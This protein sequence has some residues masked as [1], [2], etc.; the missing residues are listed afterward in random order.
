MEPLPTTIGPL[1]F[2]PKPKNLIANNQLVGTK[3][4]TSNLFLIKLFNNISTFYCYLV[5]MEPEIEADFTFKKRELFNSIERQV[6]EVYGKVSVYT[7]D[8]YFSTK[9][10]ADIKEFKALYRKT[11]A[12]YKVLI[13]LSEKTINVT[14]KNYWRTPAVK[15]IT[16]EMVRK[17]LRANPNLEF[18]RNLFVKKNEMATL[19]GTKDSKYTLNF[20]PG[21]T[22]GIH[23]LDDGTHLCIGLKNKILNTESCLEKLNSMLKSS[24]NR[25]KNQV[26]TEIKEFFQSR[27]VKTKY[28]KNNKNYVINDVNF[29]VNPGNIKFNHKGKEISMLDYYEVIKGCKITDKTQP[30]FEVVSRN[31]DN[32]NEQIIHIVPELCVLSGLDDSMIEDRYFMQELAQYTK[33]QPI[34]RIQ[35]T[36]NFK[37]LINEKDGKKVLVKDGDKTKEVTLASPLEEAKNFGMEISDPKDFKAAFLKLPSLIAANKG[38]QLNKNNGTFQFRQT[39]ETI[40]NLREWICIYNKE[41]YNSAGKLFQLMSQSSKA[42]NIDVKEPTWCETNSF[43]AKDWI[44]GVE[45]TLKGNPNINMVLFLMSKKTKRLYKEIKKHSLIEKGYLSQVVLREN[46]SDKKG[47]SVCSNIVKQ[48]NSKLGGCCYKIQFDKNIAAKNL[49]VVGV[50]SSHISGKRTGVAMCA[51]IDKQ[52]TRYTNYEEIIDEK[53][54]SQLCFAV[55]NFLER[56]VKEYY[57]ENKSLPG[58][59]VIY[60]QGVSAQQKA[61]LDDEVTQIEELLSGSIKKSVISELK[62]PYY[63]VLVNKKTTMKF[64]EKDGK[65][66][67]NS[68]PGM[69]ILDNV[70]DP[71]YHE[72]YIQPQ[73]VNEGCATPTNYH[74][75]YGDLDFS[76]YI[77]PF[78]YGLCYGYANWQGPIRVPAPLKNAEKLA[79]MVAKITKNKLND[80]LS[81]NLGYI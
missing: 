48:I 64:F 16:E 37:D 34:E 53:T 50:D 7:G 39:A 26:A 24:S 19:G 71:R 75:A 67:K 52:F 23:Y 54:K 4:V 81:N 74:V 73:F 17:V 25:N 18:Y 29:D 43:Q 32:G 42:F 49:M 47:M 20:Y 8:N 63:Y 41:D 9:K 21:Y 5:R 2:N 79:K 80:K 55:A 70:V 22:T 10:E 68:S 36:R 33:M 11:G 40:M 56:A 59:I 60:R 65:S 35:K 46:L 62:I 3:P 61:Y 28:K 45:T 69:V 1:N 30:L 76:E 38:I 31:P 77:T 57:K 66:V 72:F 13:S 6:E 58:G 44:K 14:E 51:S 15:Q 78:T 27:S 12:E